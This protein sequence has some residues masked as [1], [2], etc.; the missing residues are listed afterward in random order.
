MIVILIFLGG[1]VL[2]GF[3]VAL[4]IGMIT[5]TYSSIFVASAFVLEYANRTGKKVTF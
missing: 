3:S 4:F 1:D 2:R 5:G